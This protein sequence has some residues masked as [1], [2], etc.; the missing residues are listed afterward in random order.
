MSYNDDNFGRWDGME[1]PEMRRFYHKT[2]R[3]NVKKVCV[4][5]GQ[6]VHIQPHYECCNSCADVREGCF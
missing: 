2:Q 4:D 3:T 6:T 5:C 1:D